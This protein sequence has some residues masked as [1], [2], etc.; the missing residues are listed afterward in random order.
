MDGDTGFDSLDSGQQ[1]GSGD[2]PAWND[3]LAELPQEYHE[4]VKPHLQKWDQNFTT[5][6]GKVQQQ[7]QPWNEIISNA[8]PETT[9]FALQMMNALE[10]DPKV[11]YKAIGD[12]YKDQLGDLVQP[13]PAAQGQNEPNNVQDEKPWMNDFQQLRS[14]N[15]MLAR[16]IQQGRQ[17]EQNAA[18]DAQLDTDLKTAQGKHGAFD[19]QYV[20]GLI[21]ANPKLSV[22]QAVTTWKQSVQSYA[23]QMGFG[24]PKPFFMGGGSNIPGQGVD[25]KK[26]DEKGTKDVV[27]QMLSA[28]AAQN[29][30]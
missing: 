22:D 24:G 10:T 16:I 5:K 19:E 7:Y 4:K 8:D 28:A 9:K 1:Q 3:M 12:F 14:E 11:V 17:A 21:M 20:L 29:R 18:A 6:V 2:N 26:L 23:Q 25:V 27:V 30:Q 13:N 15:E